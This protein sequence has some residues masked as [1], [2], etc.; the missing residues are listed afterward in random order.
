M[1]SLAEWATLFGYDVERIFQAANG[2]LS[3]SSS[4][5]PGQM[6]NLRLG[7]VGAAVALPSRPVLSELDSLVE[8]ALTS[9]KQLS[10][11]RRDGPPTAAT[12]WSPQHNR[13]N[14]IPRFASTV[15]PFG[16]GFLLSVMAPPDSRALVL[17]IEVQNSVVQKIFESVLNNSIYLDLS[18][19]DPGRTVYYF[20]KPTMNQFAL[21]SDTVRRLAGEFTVSPRD[22]AERGGGKE[23]SLVSPHGGFEVRV[24]YGSPAAAVRADLLRSLSSAAVSRAW[25]REKDLVTRGFGGSAA[26]WTPAEMAELI[27]TGEVKGYEAVEIQPAER[28]PALARDATNFEFV[29]ATSGGGSGMG[30]GRRN[31]HARRKHV[32]D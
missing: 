9:L 21:D 26:D 8:A 7:S 30:R 12:G 14:L 23:L 10:F 16:Q 11:V 18:Y 28:Y 1:T 29:K 20:V 24:L 15:S 17:P 5:S 25:A 32:A 27:R 3:C 19:S 13:L 31:R 22:T 2:H 4:S 6:M